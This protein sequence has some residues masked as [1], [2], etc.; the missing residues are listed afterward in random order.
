LDNCFSSFGSVGTRIGH[1]L[2]AWRIDSCAD[3]VGRHRRSVPADY[4]TKSSLNDQDMFAIDIR[5]VSIE[6]KVP[7]GRTAC[8]QLQAVLLQ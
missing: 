7:K 6:E 3:R 4:G 2:H 1:F 8:N 5:A